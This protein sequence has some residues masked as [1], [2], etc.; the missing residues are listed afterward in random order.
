MLKI[1]KLDVGNQWPVVISTDH[2]H[3]FHSTDR[4]FTSSPTSA[5]QSES[6]LLQ[7]SK[8]VP[9]RSTVSHRG[10]AALR[11]AVRKQAQANRSEIRRLQAHLPDITASAKANYAAFVEEKL[12]DFFTLAKEI[13]NYT[14]AAAEYLFKTLSELN[15][16]LRKSVLTVLGVVGGALLSTSAI[17]LNPLTYS[18]V[19][20]SYSVFL[21][22][23]NVWYL[24]SNAARDFADHLRHFRS[25]VEPY[26]EF[27][28]AEQRREVFD[29]V[30]RQHRE[31]FAKSRK[32]VCL[33]N[34]TLALF[35]LCLSGFDIPRLAKSFVFVPTWP[36]GQGIDWL[37]R[38]IVEYL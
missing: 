24:P 13:S 32:L 21:F 12:K 28:S 10:A 33:V 17:Q 30:P 38:T 18:T 26:R 20:A 31:R 6:A 14:I 3:P 27:L 1:I 11:L 19:L 7:V 23:F 5:S 16:S 22:G 34:G 37:V 15:D 25:R 29:D 36:L 35:V 8:V 4:C 9:S 2:A